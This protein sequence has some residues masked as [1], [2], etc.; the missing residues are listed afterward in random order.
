[1][2][3]QDDVA[4]RAIQIGGESGDF[5]GDVSRT[6]GEARPCSGVAIEIVDARYDRFPDGGV[7]WW[8]R[9]EPNFGHGG[10]PIANARICGREPERG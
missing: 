10:D 3:D 7:E 8:A 4:I 2:P 9:D 5:L 6:C 1:M